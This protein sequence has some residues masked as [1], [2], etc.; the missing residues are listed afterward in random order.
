MRMG[1]IGMQRQDFK[2]GVGFG[3]DTGEFLEKG[4]IKPCAAVAGAR[5]SLDRKALVRD[6]QGQL[7]RLGYPV[8]KPDGVAG[9]KTREA[10]KAF[11]RAQGMKVNGKP[12]NELLEALKRAKEQLLRSARCFS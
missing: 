1:R 11:Q 6:I 9:G 7:N 3:A 12:D 2:P 8:G 4:K 10:I 5:Q